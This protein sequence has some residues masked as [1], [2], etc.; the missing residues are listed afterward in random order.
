[1]KLKWLYYVGLDR[2]ILVQKLSLLSLL[3]FYS[4]TLAHN[5]GNY[6]SNSLDLLPHFFCFGDCKIKP[7]LFGYYH[8]LPDGG[9]GVPVVWLPPHSTTGLFLGSVV[10]L[11]QHL[12]P[13]PTNPS[14]G[15]VLLGQLAV[16]F[17][18]SVFSVC[19]FILLMWLFAW[20]D[21]QAF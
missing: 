14:P 19:V 9:A 6:N 4:F 15:Q 18:F 8:K 20:N 10:P 2:S 12:Q 3:S 11:H 5:L 17:I 13:F 16:M 1:M 7:N 21:T